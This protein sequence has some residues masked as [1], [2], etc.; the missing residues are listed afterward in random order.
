MRNVPIAE[1]EDLDRPVL[2]IGTDYPPGHLLPLHRHRRAQLLYGA[3]G[4]MRVETAD[5]DWTVPAHRAVLVPAGTDHQ[6]LMNGVTTRSLYLEPRAVP[7]F[8]DRCRVVEVSPLLRELLLAAVDVE[9]EY[10]PAGRDG[11]LVELVLHEIRS[12]APLP[13]DLPLPR[14]PGLRRLCE[15]FLAAPDVHDPSSRWAA[16]LHVGERTF[17]RLF[18]AQTG[19]TF[20]A[21]R[22]RACA[23]H[24]VRSLASGRTVT[25]VAAEL[26]YGNPAAFTTMVKRETGSAPSAFR[27]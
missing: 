11:A 12:L 24:A 4:V 6:V 22:Q 7:W 13:F 26:G 21:W 5:G 20:H 23:L 16:E 8:P 25:S 2:A 27:P 14:H 10:D 18:P 19:S 9:P 3:T 17:S 1:L 15:R